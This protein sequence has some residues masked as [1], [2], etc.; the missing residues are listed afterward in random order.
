[1]ATTLVSSSNLVLSTSRYHPQSGQV[2]LHGLPGRQAVL[3]LS[4]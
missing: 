4:V 1:M 2:G 3:S